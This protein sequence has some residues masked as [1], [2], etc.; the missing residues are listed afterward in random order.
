MAAAVGVGAA[1]LFWKEAVW[2][3]LSAKRFAVVEPG[4]IYRSGKATPNALRRMHEAYGIRTIVDLGAY[5]EG[6]PEDV[7]EA[8]AAESLGIDRVRFD[9]AGDSTGNANAYVVALRMMTDPARQ[10]VLV[11]CGAGTERTGCA[12]V[13]YRHIMQGVSI[14][15]AY[16]EA[17]AAGHRPGTNHALRGTLDR[18]AD[19]IERA[20]RD[21]TQIPGIATV[22]EP[23]PPASVGAKR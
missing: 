19:P 11:H 16:L 23:P 17:Q 2:S 8:R 15:D 7:R 3:N 9:L 22:P 13:L 5:P 10:P 4:K 20:Y 14:D 12:V 6:S 1:A 21:G 18:W